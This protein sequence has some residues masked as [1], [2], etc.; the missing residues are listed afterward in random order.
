ME[1]LL[2]RYPK[3]ASRIQERA[4]RDPVFRS[5]CD[6]Y[7]DTFTALL[8]WRNSSSPSSALRIAEFNQILKELGHE[9]EEALERKVDL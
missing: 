5:V 9:I 8:N 2:E 1:P 6:D 3:E 7:F 4:L